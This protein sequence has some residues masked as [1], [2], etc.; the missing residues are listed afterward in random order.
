VPVSH[1]GFYRVSSAVVAPGV[2]SEVWVAG[3]NYCQMA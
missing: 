1:P 2:Q 3:G